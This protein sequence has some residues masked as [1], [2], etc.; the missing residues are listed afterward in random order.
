MII[1]LILRLY[2]ISYVEISKVLRNFNCFDIRTTH[3]WLKLIVENENDLHK[4]LTQDKRGKY[5]REEFYEIYPELENEAKLF[6]LSQSS[7]KECSFKAKDLCEF[8][9]KRVQEITGKIINNQAVFQ[10]FNFSNKN[11]ELNSIRN[12]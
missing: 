10:I 9:T 7:K 4:I 1:Y 8:L 2:K 6:S 11:K 5:K 12:Y 3:S